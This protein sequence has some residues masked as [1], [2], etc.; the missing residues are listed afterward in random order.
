MK[1]QKLGKEGENLAV[2]FLLKKGFKV[3]TRNYRNT[4]GEIDII[5]LEGKSLVF[6]EVKTRRSLEFGNPLESVNKK[7]QMKLKKTAYFF[8]NNYKEHFNE[9][10]FDVISIIL[11]NND[12]PNIEHIRHAF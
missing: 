9:M 7:K 10:R 2:D 3:I 1:R 6:V 5:A 4:F 8:L 11:Q 12:N